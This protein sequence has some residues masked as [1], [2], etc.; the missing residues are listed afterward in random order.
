[1]YHECGRLTLATAG[2][3]LP[4]VCIVFYCTGHML[5]GGHS[6]HAQDMSI[7]MIRFRLYVSID[8]VIKYKN[9]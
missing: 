3:L 6:D 9:K 1:M 7:S 4:F 8:K 2:L 5:C